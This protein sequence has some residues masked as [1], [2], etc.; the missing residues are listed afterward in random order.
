MGARPQLRQPVRA[1]ASHELQPCQRGAALL[2]LLLLLLLLRF[3]IL[4]THFAA[5]EPLQHAAPAAAA[6]AVKAAAAAATPLQAAKAASQGRAAGAGIGLCRPAAL[7][8]GASHSDAGAAASCRW[9]ARRGL[10]RG[11]R[12]DP[13]GGGW[14]AGR[15]PRAGSPLAR[16]HG[17][18]LLAVGW[19]LQLLHGKLKL[20]VR[21][22]PGLAWAAMSAARRCPAAA[23]LAA[24]FAVVVPPLPLLLRIRRR[25]GRCQLVCERRRQGFGRQPAEGAGAAGAQVCGQ[26]CCQPRPSIAALTAMP[27]WLGGGCAARALSRCAGRCWACHPAAAG[28]PLPAA[29][30]APPAIF[31]SKPC[32]AGIVR[33]AEGSWPVAL[34]QLRG[35]AADLPLLRR[36]QAF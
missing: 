19:Q 32:T 5:A 18:A 11:C 25:L 9:G 12:P 31:Q 36:Q 3:L 26:Q 8:V 27:P 33:R 23:A 7:A 30:A 13:G 2:L 6:H 22:S 24:R 14:G 10:R 16:S 21:W 20:L 34:L 1:A 17:A 28:A 29:A 15:G 35:C 4:Q